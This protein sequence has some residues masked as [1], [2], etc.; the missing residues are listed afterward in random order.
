[1]CFINTIVTAKETYILNVK[2]QE[3]TKANTIHQNGS[4]K[5]K[6]TSKP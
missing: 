5:K 3:A 1:M 6:N 4:W 2:G